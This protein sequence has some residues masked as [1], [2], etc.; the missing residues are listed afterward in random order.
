M[1]I[2]IPENINDITLVQYQR[3]TE[4]MNR[5]DLKEHDRNV[6]KIQIFTGLKPE[7]VKQISSNDYAEIISMI[8]LALEKDHPFTPTFFIQDV[9]F[10]FV[11]NLDKIT[12]GEYIDISKYENDVQT[13]H[14]L[15]AVLFRPILKKDALDNYSI[16]SYQGT[17]QYAE[18]MKLIPLS[19]V[20]G[21]LVFFSSLSNELLNYTQ[22]FLEEEQARADKRQTTLKSGGGMQRLTNWLRGNYGTMIKS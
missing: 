6:R 12:A 5:D 3:Y 9:E 7:Q 15:M 8:D 17:E 13:F 21:A 10:G 11:P 4:L 19:A 1:K 18:V 2:T 22:R 16:I 20:T 14:N